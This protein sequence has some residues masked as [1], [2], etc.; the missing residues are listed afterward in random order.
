V[1]SAPWWHG[2]AIDD[3]VWRDTG[4]ALAARAAPPPAPHAA[5]VTAAAAAAA[6][7]AASSRPVLRLPLAFICASFAS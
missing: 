4:S 3:P 2:I 6:R 1:A 5:L 7:I